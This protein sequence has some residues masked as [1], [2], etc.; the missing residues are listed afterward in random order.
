M[1]KVELTNQAI[2]FFN[3]FDRALEHMRG[4]IHISFPKHTVSEIVESGE[5][6]RSH[7]GRKIG[8]LEKIKGVA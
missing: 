6:F 3:G 8:T 4:Q 7:D 2:I 5:I 1:Y